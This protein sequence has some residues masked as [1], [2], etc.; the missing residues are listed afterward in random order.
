MSDNPT[1]ENQ[2]NS[3]GSFYERPGVQVESIP[4]GPGVPIGIERVSNPEIGIEQ[5]V[6]RL[7]RMLRQC[8]PARAG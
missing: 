7:G 2:L 5:H 4:I 8:Y 3:T 6:R 1:P